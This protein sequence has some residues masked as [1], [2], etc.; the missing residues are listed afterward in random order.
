MNDYS[1]IWDTHKNG[2]V[3]AVFRLNGRLKWERIGEKKFLTKEAINAKKRA[4]TERLAKGE[5]LT[6]KKRFD[7][8]AMEYLKYAEA[9]RTPRTFE[10][11]KG[12]VKKL[13]GYFKG[14]MIVQ[15]SPYMVEGYMDHRR[16]QNPRLSDKMIINELFTLSALFRMAIKRGYVQDNP[17]KRIEMPKYIRPEMK[18]FTKAEIALMMTNC[19]RYM[20]GILLL[21]LTTGMRS[22]EI[23]NL[24]WANVDMDNDIIH[25]KC[26]ES[27]KTKNKKNR[28]VAMVPL[29]KDEL[30][31]LKNNWVD[32]FKDTVMPRQDHQ[33]QYVFCHANGERIKYFNQ[34]FEKLM[35]K[36]GIKNAS[37]H[38]MRHTF[39]TYHSNYGDPYMTQ[40]IAGHSDQRTTQG[41]YHLQLDR[42]KTSMEPIMQMMN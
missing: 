20:R 10:S 29:L 33:R 38:T 40:R 17:V 27:F 41:Y 21:G 15:I 34:A 31:F 6:V 12:N 3:Y 36:L 42:M 7:Q 9:N 32:P 22:A 24:K 13:A 11:I 1:R 2:I 8:V 16:A 35:K 26:D 18:F 5:Y 39:I 28:I 37:P 14:H 30:M 25:I 19:S 23:V 4:I